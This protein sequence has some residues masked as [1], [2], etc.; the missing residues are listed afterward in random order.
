MLYVY[1][2]IR[3]CV[4]VRMCLSGRWSDAFLACVIGLR[5]ETDAFL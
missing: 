1:K 2:C 5:D 4:C 3:M